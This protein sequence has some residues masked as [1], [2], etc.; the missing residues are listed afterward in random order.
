MEVVLWMYPLVP[1][2][3]ILIGCGFLNALSLLPTEVSL[4][5]GEGYTY[6]WV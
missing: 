1:K 5:M 3:C 6:L 4:M 2:L